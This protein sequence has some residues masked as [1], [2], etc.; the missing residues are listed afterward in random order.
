MTGEEAGF[1]R[2]HDEPSRCLRL[3]PGV[4][5][6]SSHFTLVE[7]DGVTAGGPI[8]RVQC[9]LTWTP[10][11]VTLQVAL[12]GDYHLPYQDRYDCMPRLD[13]RRLVL[14][15]DFTALRLIEDR[16]Q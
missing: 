4:G 10:I 5:E 7:D 12:S 11:E 14:S 13:G 1:A 3:F 15:S 6:G 16:A 9:T 8:T 2:L